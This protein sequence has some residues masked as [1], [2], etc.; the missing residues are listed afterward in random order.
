LTELVGNQATGEQT[1]PRSREPNRYA[2]IIE[3]V[4]LA[5]YRDGAEQV[6]FTRDDLERAA[7]VLNVKLPKNIGDVIYSFRFRSSFPDAISSRAPKGKSWIIRLAGRSRYCFVANSLTC[8]SPRSDLVATKI[9]DAT[10]GMIVKY[11][12][13]D[14]QALL[15]ILRYNRL[16]DVFTRVTC[17]S[18]QSHLRTTAVGV[19]QVETDELYIGVDRF[20]TH[21]VFP[22][23]A[24]GGRDRQSVVQIEQD[25]AICREKFPS[26]VCRP[27]A[28]QF[29]HND[30][31][32]MFEFEQ[33]GQEIV[34]SSEKHYRLVPPEDVT[35]KDLEAYQTASRGC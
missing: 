19:G 1:M 5:H 4:F 8:I 28:A 18:L 25:L 31:I 20:G 10:P 21:Y 13:S 29:M 16:V 32:A 33:Q 7:A 12:L 11:A 14:E 6:F 35:D 9:P 30:T 17:Y 26:L 15:A 34:I 22:V 2:R 27:V 24:K 3:R 23:Q